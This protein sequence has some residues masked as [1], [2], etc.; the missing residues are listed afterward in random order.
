MSSPMQSIES[1]LTPG[2]TL[3]KRP[4]PSFTQEGVIKRVLRFLIQNNLSF[5]AL[6]SDSF[7]QLMKYL[8][9]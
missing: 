4:K 8:N 9:P 2:T 7:E 1:F 6:S 3:A 5:N